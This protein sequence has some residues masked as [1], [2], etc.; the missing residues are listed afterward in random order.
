MSLKKREQAARQIERMREEEGVNAV[1]FVFH[2][3]RE[4]SECRTEKQFQY[5]RF[6]V[7]A[8]ADLVIMHHPHVVQGISVLDGRSVCYSLG[9]FCFGGNRRVRALE[10]LIVAAELTFADDGT[11]TGCSGLTASSMGCHP[12]SF[13]RV[14]E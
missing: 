11:Y 5:A 4:Y 14:T 1:V 12:P 9:N 13:Q 6:A 8:G 10:S 2:A 7:D 3:G